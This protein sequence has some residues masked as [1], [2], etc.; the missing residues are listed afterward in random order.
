M[1]TLNWFAHTLTLKRVILP[2]WINVSG[3]GLPRVDYFNSLTK[4]GTK[5]QM[6]QSERGLVHA[7][8]LATVH[9]LSSMR[10]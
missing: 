1:T 9:T 8:M 5:N 3:V 6:G 2:G 10:R 4:G 7:G